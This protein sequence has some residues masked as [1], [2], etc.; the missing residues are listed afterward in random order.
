MRVGRISRRAARA[1]TGDPQD[2]IDLPALDQVSGAF[3]YLNFE[4]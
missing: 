3:D 4:K 1:T 2:E